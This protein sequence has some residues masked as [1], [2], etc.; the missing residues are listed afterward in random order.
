MSEANGL[1]ENASGVELEV[2]EPVPAIVGLVSSVGETT[3]RDASSQQDTLSIQ[4]L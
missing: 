3:F 4:C 2:E 1:S